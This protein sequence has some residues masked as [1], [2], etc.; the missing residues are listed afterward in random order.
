MS[1]VLPD[2]F[3]DLIRLTPKWL[4][5]TERE[6]HTVRLNSPREELIDVYQTLLPRIDAICE[7]VDR[8]PLHEL[9]D[10]V[11]NLLR[12]ALA[13]MEVSLAVEAFQ[14]SPRVPFGFDTER[15][16]VHF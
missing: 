3:E 15:W 13:F 16:R 14:G 4:G 9:P 8:Y 1:G 5:A 6:R 12:L 11:E 10:D 7:A 2:G